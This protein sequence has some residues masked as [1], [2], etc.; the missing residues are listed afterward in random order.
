MLLGEADELQLCSAR[1]VF[2]AHFKS[3]SRL[4]IVS[5]QVGL[6]DIQSGRSSWTKWPLRSTTRTSS[7]TSGLVITSVLALDCCAWTRGAS[8]VRKAT[9]TENEPTSVRRF[10]HTDPVWW[11]RCAAVPHLR[12]TIY[13]YLTTLRLGTRWP[14]EPSFWR[15]IEDK[16]H[17]GRANVSSIV[18]DVLAAFEPAP[19]CE[20]PTEMP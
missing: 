20:L 18:K 10:Q 8:C 4:Q 5:D 13:S 17:F 7:T 3:E 15:L 2:R 16:A 19:G 1:Q 11:D 6:P 14:P 12:S 9:A